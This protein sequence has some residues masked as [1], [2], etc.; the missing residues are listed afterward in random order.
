MTSLLFILHL[1]GRNQWLQ[2]N[3]PN[4]QLGP[5]LGCILKVQMFRPKRSLDAKHLQGL[6][7]L[8][9]WLCTQSL[10]SWLQVL[11]RPDHWREYWEDQWDHRH[12]LLCL[13]HQQQSTRIPRPT[14]T[15]PASPGI[16]IYHRINCRIY[17]H[18]NK[19]FD[20]V[21]KYL[22]KKVLWNY[23]IWKSDNFV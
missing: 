5:V 1:R 18:T 9:V 8:S 7:H 23:R 11:L 16:F 3:Q 13:H 10:Q 22:L 17:S 15:L 14:I 4:I 19:L 20:Q 21:T 2:F 6:S 12:R